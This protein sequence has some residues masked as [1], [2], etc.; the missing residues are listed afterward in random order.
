MKQRTEVTHRIT[1]WEEGVFGC[2]DT[3][4]LLSLK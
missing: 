1:V 3:L 4:R 2:L